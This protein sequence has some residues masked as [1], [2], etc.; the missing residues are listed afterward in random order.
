MQ[1]LTG[2]NPNEL[3]DAVELLV[4][5]GYLEWLRTMG[6]APYHFRDVALTAEG[7]YEYERTSSKSVQTDRQEEMRYPPVPIGS[8]YGFTDQDWEMVVETKSDTSKVNIIFGCAFQSPNYDT[9]K[10]KENVESTFKKALEIYNGRP[11]TLRIDL[12]FSSLSAG[13]GEH[14]FNEIARDIISADIA[15][16]DTSDLN[17]NVMLEMGVALTWGI[18]VLPIKNDKCPKP[19]SDI[20][21]QTWADYKDSGEVWTDAKSEEKIVR[22]IERA[23]RKKVAR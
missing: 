7:R 16:F 19:P 18:R 12:G 11:G 10:L 22:M 21:G 6:T 8:P 13:Y 5:Y 9:D 1:E 17:P 23:M 3:N 14:L 15:V 20:S 4:K 2:L